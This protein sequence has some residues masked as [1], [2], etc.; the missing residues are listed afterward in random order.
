MEALSY[1]IAPGLMKVPHVFKHV[2]EKEVIEQICFKY[3]ITPEQ[4]RDRSKKPDRVFIR[5]LAMYLL[6]KQ[7]GR[8]YSYI[9]WLF[10]RD[11]ATVMYAVR[12]I[13]NYI[14]TDSFGKRS[15]ILSF[16]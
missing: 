16:L 3:E 12:S 4:L 6:R 13:E 14:E 5:H 1:Y 15:E 10:D 7:S 11:H 9:G 2:D 8:A